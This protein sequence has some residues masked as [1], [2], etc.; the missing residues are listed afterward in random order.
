MSLPFFLSEACALHVPAFLAV[1]DQE[2]LGG[3]SRVGFPVVVANDKEA[4]G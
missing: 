1:Q 3:S 4:N 2:R